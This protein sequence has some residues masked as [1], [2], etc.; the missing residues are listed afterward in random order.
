MAFLTEQELKTVATAEVVDKITNNDN[1]IV[2]EII[3]E[4]IDLMRSY[5]FR[6]YDTDSIFSAVGDERSR[7]VLKY[8]KDIVIHEIYIRRTKTYNEVAKMRY[9]EAMLWLEKV[10]FGKIDA[11]LPRKTTDTDGDG[12]ADDTGS[13]FMKL[14]G[15]KTYKN[16]W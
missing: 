14:G 5:L 15:R 13:G 7:V 16:H 8:L 4:S 6:Y 9:D 11:D 10:G 2:T 1:E 3:A 12:V